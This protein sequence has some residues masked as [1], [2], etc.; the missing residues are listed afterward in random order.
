MKV[1]LAR[2]HDFLV[3]SMRAWL[4]ALQLEPVRLK[5]LDELAAH[6]AAEVGAVVIS[7]AVTSTVRESPGAT[8]VAVRRRLPQVPVLVA[9][10][11]SFASARAGLATEFPGATLHSADEAA[12]WGEPS[13]IL[14]VSAEELRA[15]APAL[16]A[17][18]RRH[19]R[20]AAPT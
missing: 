3:D 12:A 10:L 19:L 7:A 1:L 15:R 5:S 6:A 9:G 11:A 14:Y 18:T 4:S 2:P 20:L 8:L 13:I 16:D 17:A